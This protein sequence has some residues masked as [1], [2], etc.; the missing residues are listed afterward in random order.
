MSSSTI[1]PART[2]RTS[3]C[4]ALSGMHGRPVL[5]WSR[6]P[7]MYSLGPKMPWAIAAPTTGLA[8][9]HGSPS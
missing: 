8:T 2:V 4:V 7:F 1:V 6:L 3:R 9:S 5:G